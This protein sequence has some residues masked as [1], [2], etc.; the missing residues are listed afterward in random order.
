[1]TTEQ[2]EIMA[3]KIGKHEQQIED[4]QSRFN[5]RYAHL[6]TEHATALAALQ[7]KARAEQAAEKQRL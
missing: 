7:E 1:M 6:E 5:E 3:N 4:L 2:S